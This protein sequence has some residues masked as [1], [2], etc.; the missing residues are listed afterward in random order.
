MP[1][2]SAAHSVDCDRTFDNSSTR[3][4]FGNLVVDYGQVQGKINMKYDAWHKELLSQFAVRLGHA[5]HELHA[6]LLKV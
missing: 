5:M 6:N 3:A 2:A 1:C 4:V